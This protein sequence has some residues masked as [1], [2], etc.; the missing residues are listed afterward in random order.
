MLH[1]WRYNRRLVVTLSYTLT[2]AGVISLWTLQQDA[3]F[4]LL[5]VFVLCFGL[6]Q[7]ARGPVISTLVSKLYP[8]HVG[9]IYGAVT[10]GLGL[11]AALGS[12]LSGYLYDLTGS[13]DA[14]FVVSLVASL[15]GASQ[16]WISR[17]L[18][19]GVHVRDARR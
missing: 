17:P 6:S 10:I 7:G 8:D 18:A 1:V 9:P 15:A 12:W 11:G 5:S 13:Y 4:L 2:A 14:A 19:T 16:F 3:S